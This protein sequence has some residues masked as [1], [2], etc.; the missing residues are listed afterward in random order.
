MKALILAAGFGTRLLPYTEHTPKALFT[1]AG[2]PVLER[3]IRQ[4]AGSGFTGIIINTHHLSHRIEAYLRRRR[5]PV[6]VQIRYEPQ[7]LGTG[8]AIKNVADFWESGPLMVLNGDV[9]SDIDLKQVCEFHRAHPWPVTMVLHDCPRYNTVRVDSENW[10][11][12]FEGSPGAKSSA[13][14]LLAF[15][16]IQVIEPEVLD[17]I[18]STGFYHS[19][20]AY[21]NMI[22]AGRK[23]MGF[24]AAGCYWQ[25]IGTPESYSETVFD[26]MSVPA[27]NVA[28]P[29][30]SIGEVTRS[31][32]KG[33][34]SDRHWYRLQSGHRTI[35]MV[36]HGIRRNS[37]TAEAD[38]FVSI[39]RH[40]KERTINVPQIYLYDLFSG[41]VYLEDLGDIHL[42]DLV[43][44][45]RCREDLVNIYK[46]I[47]GQLIHMW[48]AGAGDFDPSWTC[49]T[50]E[51][52]RDLILEKECRY[53]AEAF[54]QDA[55]GRPS[56]FQTLETEFGRLAD[57]ALLHAE[58]GF[59]H[60]DL[61]SRNIMVREGAFYFIDFQGGRMGPLQ[62]DLAA[63]LIDPYTDL[64]DDVRSELLDFA[65][66]RLQERHGIDAVRFRKG[67]GYCALTRNLQ[68]LGAFGYLSK[69][70][71]VWFEQYI[72]AAVRSL[73]QTLS[74]DLGNE[75][76][77]L[78]QIAHTL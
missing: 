12:G 8:G 19:I 9:V 18:P 54:V 6:P 34:G 50:A 52:S 72:P 55:L 24:I 3:V 65:A 43:R 25:D 4:L 73:K 75:F 56:P 40:L 68:V 41:Q 7:I 14:R 35:V 39:G 62:Y 17:F 51:Y 46:T 66:S 1:I 31:K 28:F 11:M 69:G 22:A 60:R 53:F 78:H 44:R 61:Q 33:D 5:H 2:E 57:Q 70:G 29:R 26:L 59:M 10:V 13:R 15:T 20:D 48:S 42:Q 67:Y 63:L 36:D 30:S 23:I 16:G 76:P 77:K 58:R 45:T 74:T 47:T 37:R 64:T 38:A 32:L 27:F 71:K 21:R 49:Q